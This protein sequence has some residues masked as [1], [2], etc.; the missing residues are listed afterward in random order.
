M[1]DSSALRQ[2]YTGE[3]TIDSNGKATLSG[4]FTQNGA[5][6]YKWTRLSHVQIDFKK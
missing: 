6:S 5:G 3:L 1:W 4:T 2:D